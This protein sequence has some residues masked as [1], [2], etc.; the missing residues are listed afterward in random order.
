MVSQD[1]GEKL[2]KLS[3]MIE[4]TVDLKAADN[5]TYLIKPDFHPE[6]LGN[7]LH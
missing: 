5:H 4:T 1:Y 7:T 6:L 3:E 2:G